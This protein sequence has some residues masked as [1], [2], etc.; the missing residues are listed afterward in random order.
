[1]RDLSAERHLKRSTNSRII[2]GPLLQD[3]RT[4]NH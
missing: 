3:V 4:E 2:C 1:M